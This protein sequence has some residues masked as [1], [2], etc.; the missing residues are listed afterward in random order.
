MARP[1]YSSS[2]RTEKT[3]PPKALSRANAGCRA[4]NPLVE[5]RPIEQLIS[6]FYLVRLYLQC[7]IWDVLKWS[8][9]RNFSEDELMSSARVGVSFLTKL[10]R[11][12]YSGGFQFR[13]SIDSATNSR[14][15][16]LSFV[17][18]SFPTVQRR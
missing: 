15:L 12:A 1:G 16:H 10:F 2:K 11:H 7:E 17:S 5:S 18:D 6:A 8:K 4:K 13:G 3:L 9:Y 14:F